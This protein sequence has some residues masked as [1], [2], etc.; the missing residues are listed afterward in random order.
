MECS[1]SRGKSINASI[2]NSS[3]FTS[4]IGTPQDI[5]GN[6][7]CSDNLCANVS[8]SPQIELSVVGEGVISVTTENRIATVTSKTYI[9]EQ[10]TSSDTWEIEHNLNKYPSVTVID[11]AGRVFTAQVEYNSENKCTVY[12]NAAT[13]GKAYLN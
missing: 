9:H 4:N 10:G 5:S 7:N 11:T 6:V 13:K 2:K 12:I 3:V 8:N 1:I